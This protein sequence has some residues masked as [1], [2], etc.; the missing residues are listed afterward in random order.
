MCWRV[1]LF[2]CPRAFKAV[3]ER[4]G[5]G[6]SPEENMLTEPA[7]AKRSSKGRRRMA[8]DPHGMETVKQF[9]R[10]AGQAQRVTSWRIRP[11]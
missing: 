9:L 11:S 3:T 10:G 7:N 4:R 2:Q 8:S 1:D 6:G 5:H